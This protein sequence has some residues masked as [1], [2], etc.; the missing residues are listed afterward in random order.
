M[1]E[2]PIMDKEGERPKV[3]QFIVEQ[4]CTKAGDQPITPEKPVSGRGQSEQAI[5]ADAAGECKETEYGE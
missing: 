4:T 3:E 2:Q 5:L 1:G